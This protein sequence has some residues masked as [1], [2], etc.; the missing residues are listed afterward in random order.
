[1]YATQ[2][3]YRLKFHTIYNDSIHIYK[4]LR[5]KCFPSHPNPNLWLIVFFISTKAATASKEVEG[6]WGRVRTYF[7]RRLVIKEFHHPCLCWLQ[8]RP[9]SACAWGSALAGLARQDPLECP[10]TRKRVGIAKRIGKGG[11]YQFFEAGS[12]WLPPKWLRCGMGS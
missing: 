1:M 3:L 4:L 12:F 2:V 6:G 9:A 5:L 7:L 11:P 10:S 8:P